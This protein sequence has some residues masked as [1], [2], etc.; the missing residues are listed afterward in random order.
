MDGE[1]LDWTT[2]NKPREVRTGRRARAAPAFTLEDSAGGIDD[3]DIGNDIGGGS[4]SPGPPRPCRRQGGWADDTGKEKKRPEGKKSMD[5]AVEDARLRSD[6]PP[7]RDD[8]DEDIPVIPD[9]DDVQEED[10]ATQI[11]APPS[12]QVNKIATYRELDTDLF[13]QAAFLILD[14]EIDL[15]PLAKCLSAETDVLEEDKPWDWDRLFTEV[16]SELQVEW[17]AERPKE[18]DEPLPMQ[19]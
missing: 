11:A 17:E 4:S 8:S 7:R 6:S 16:T 15:K 1:E 13:K 12:L 2:E 5:D 9:L 14:D 19:G 18:E 10:M 3:D